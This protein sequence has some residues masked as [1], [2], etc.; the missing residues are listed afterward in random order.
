MK[1]VDLTIWNCHQ[2]R[3]IRAIE[4]KA[5]ID[6]SQMNTRGRNSLLRMIE[7]A[8]VTSSAHAGV[9]L[10]GFKLLESTGM[11]FLS[12]KIR[13]WRS[14]YWGHNGNKKPPEGF[15]AGMKRL[16]DADKVAHTLEK[17]SHWYQDASGTHQVFHALRPQD[18]V[19]ELLADYVASAEYQ[20]A[21]TPIVKAIKEGKTLTVN[22]KEPRGTYYR[23]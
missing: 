22:I 13:G 15:I 18:H 8:W 10:L 11:W 1:P 23:S 14:Q 16:A 21:V 20:A 7:G 5:K 12:G 19:P 3:R 4:F 9:G 2:L 17:G 6:F